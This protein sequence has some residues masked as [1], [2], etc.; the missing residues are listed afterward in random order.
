MF[1]VFLS[2]LAVFFALAL[3][4]VARLVWRRVRR[5]STSGGA[6]SEPAKDSRFSDGLLL[7]GVAMAWYSVA[8]G[9]ICQLIIYPIYPDM[10]PFG[11]EA[12]HG[13]SRAYLSRLPAVILP[14]GMMCL[15]WVL[16]LWVRRPTVS[17]RIV[18]AIVGLCV[19]IVAVTPISAGAQDQMYLSGF[20]SD[21]H[22][23]L[24]W[25][26]GIRVL[27]VTIIGVLSLAALRG[28]WGSARSNP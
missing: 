18:W 12:F 25:S 4:A 26:N 19:A 16:L 5:T 10:S 22:L 8:S 17:P 2:M 9:W 13:F 24:M 23:R 1:V 27:L 20:S 28:R 6:T 15:A 7:L 14:M 21:L 11:E 3:G